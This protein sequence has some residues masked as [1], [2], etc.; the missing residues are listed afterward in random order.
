SLVVQFNEDV[1]GIAKSALTL[2]DLNSN[3]AVDL[4]KIAFA[5]DAAAHAATITFPG[6]PGGRLPDAN[7]RATFSAAAVKDQATNAL[8]GN[9][10]GTAGDNYSADFFALEGDA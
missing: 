5:Y 4:N 3:S 6:F 8:D 9:G 7:Y 1:A 10:D 2:T